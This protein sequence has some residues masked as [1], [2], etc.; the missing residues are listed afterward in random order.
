MY[1]L[2]DIEPRSDYVESEWVWC[3]ECRH[4][5]ESGVQ[6]SGTERYDV[7]AACDNAINLLTL[8]VPDGCLLVD[9]GELLFHYNQE[10]RDGE[11]A[12]ELWTCTKCD[13]VF[14]HGD[15]TRRFSGEGKKSRDYTGFVMCGCPSCGVE[16]YTERLKDVPDGCLAVSDGVSANG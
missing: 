3:P 1:K 2:D 5:G 11:Q 16:H 6:E 4:E 15:I 8:L 14:P 10:Y 13:S 7:C 9:E 12:Q